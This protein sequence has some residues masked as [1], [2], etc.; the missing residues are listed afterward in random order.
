MS[1]VNFA[2]NQFQDFNQFNPDTVALMLTCQYEIQAYFRS[3]YWSCSA[4]NAVES[5]NFT[6]LYWFVYENQTVPFVLV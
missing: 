4:T 1:F 3:I 5:R 6:T 2:L